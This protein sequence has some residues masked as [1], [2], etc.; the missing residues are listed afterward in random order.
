MK[1]LIF[2]PEHE[3]FRETC[4]AFCAKEVAPHHS[5]WERAG[6]VPRDLWLRAG[7]LGLLG[8]MMPERYGGAG[9]EDF[10]FN[11]VFNEELTKIGAG[12]PGMPLRNDI[13]SGY[14]LHLTTAEQ[15]ERWLPGFCDGSLI[16]AIAMTEPEAGSD[17]QGIRTTAVRDGDCYLLNGQKTFITNGINADLVVV[18]AKTPLNGHQEITLL[19]VERG[20]PGF[21]RGR[22]L[23]KIGLKAQDTAE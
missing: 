16:S 19:V 13:V 8:F 4:K 12:G 22:N 1:R 11:A 7:S 21:S 2:E 23:D 9:V 18:V 6:I 20:M 14:L 10:R 3:A 5:E 17:L 15:K